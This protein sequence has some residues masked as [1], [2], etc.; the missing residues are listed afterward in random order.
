MSITVITSIISNFIMY[1]II[2]DFFELRYKRRYSTTVCFV[3]MLL[4]S[5][6][7]A[8]VNLIHNPSVNM[9]TCVLMYALINVFLYEISNKKDILINIS[10]FISMI[11]I[12]DVMVNL[13]VEF[14]FKFAEITDDAISNNMKMVLCAF[15]EF[16][17]YTL[18]KNYF[19][20]KD[21]QLLKVKDILSY[22]VISL[23]SLM[24]CGI[25]VSF[26]KEA[27]IHLRLFFFFISIVMLLFNIYYV[28]M[29]E[30]Q[31]RTY[32]MQKN[33]ELME[34]Q[35]KYMYQHYRS[36]EEKD[37]ASRKILH[38]IKNHLQV[39]DNAVHIKGTN[40]YDYIEAIKDKMS[41]LS[42][43]YLT[44][45]RLLDILLNE[46]IAEAKSHDIQL[47][48]DTDNVNLNF[49]NEYDLVT[50]FSNILDNA[51]EAVKKL[52]LDERKIYLHIKQNHNM[53]VVREKNFC[54]INSVHLD[55]NHHI[56][57]SKRNHEG[58]GLLNI[59]E[60]LKNYNANM[61]I[62]TSASQFSV[63][64]V[65]FEQKDYHSDKKSNHLDNL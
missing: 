14:I 46:K 32:Q 15:Q 51:M 2:F 62:D 12:L 23:V 54:E 45:H 28:K 16:I 58:L 10:F 50:I 55:K 47:H 59:Q 6:I 24:I 64:I 37:K 48:L 40:E 20:K 13:L 27:N 7:N 35:S 9:V 8:M 44:G 53:I 42:D 34:I 33:M 11:L 49:I 22:V 19:L 31:S 17:V 29:V 61:N 38:D 52:T 4:I 5:L 60:A 21:I 57:S 26:I 65:F 30:F 25:S 63:T 1:F 3:C 18:L 39:L 41:V 43:N 56:R 36:L